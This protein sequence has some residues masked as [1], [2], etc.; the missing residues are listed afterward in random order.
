MREDYLSGEAS[1]LNPVEKEFEKA[2]RPQ[3]FKDFFGQAKV[4]ENVKI[5]VQAALQR[6]EPLDHVLKP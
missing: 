6:S 5:F 2:L 4:I 3:S 1:G